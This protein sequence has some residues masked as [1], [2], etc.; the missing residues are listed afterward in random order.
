MKYTLILSILTLLF[1]A[2]AQQPESPKLIVGI[3]VDQMCYDYLYRF[4]S[5]FSDG[6][7]KRLMNNGTNCR[8][9]HYNYVPT[10]TGPGHASIYTGTTPNNH[11][12]VAN[13]WIDRKK[14]ANLNCVQDDQAKTVGSLSNGGKCSPHLLKTPTVTDQ[15]KMTFPNAKVI[16]MS[17]KDRGAILPGGHLS[18]GTYWY[19]YST[20]HF[21]TSSFYK[22][23]LPNWVNEFNAQN[24]V[25]KV[26]QESWET[27]LPI[28]QYT[29]SQPDDSPYEQRLGGKTSA[30][31]PYDLKEMT[32]VLSPFELFTVTP[33]SNTYLADFA[34]RS[35]TAENLGDDN[36]TDMLLVS[37]STPDI[38]GHAF[39]PYSVEIQDIYLRLDIEI[40]RLL[41]EL[42]K[43]IGKRDYVFFVTAD[44][45]VVPVPQHL[46]DQKLPGGYFY[47]AD[48][49]NSLKQLV[50]QKF[51]SD[52]IIGEDN[53][54][55]YINRSKVDS[56]A[57]DLRTIQL[58]IADHI[59]NWEG[60]KAV[61]TADE[62]VSFSTD[63][64]WKEM[65]QKGYDFNRSGDVIFMLES[66][67]LAKS[68]ETETSKRGT[69]HGS[70]FNYD[71]QVPLL[72]Y[73]KRIKKQ[74][75]HR[76][77][78]ITDI[79]ATLIQMMYLQRNGSM[80]GQPI[81]EL[82]QK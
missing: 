39:G 60:V 9:T 36:Q 37:F 22:A 32:K 38:A 28:D 12:I 29:E 16:S 77:V 43:E 75:I 65:I 73:G 41:N 11:G 20:G 58:F 62:L 61:F 50:I 47:L 35:I 64:E 14:S 49:L 33:F 81:I 45:A 24:Y 46:V 51:G 18:D 55:I 68:V 67:Y 1:N 78:Q 70:A 13:D 57:L 27:L 5:K 4:S 76:R 59:R 19:D 54:N 30:T 17:I 80:T 7:F 40:E 23:A 34:I 74:S 21:I 72:W 44:H 42:D 2:N 53:L 66:G 15:L 8:N 25:N 71:T 48:R 10:Y 63:H 79:A 6:G 3:V 69:S 31:F 82:L 52:L 56:L 26:M